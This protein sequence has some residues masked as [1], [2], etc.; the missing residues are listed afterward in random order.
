VAVMYAGQIVE[1]APTVE[2][3]SKPLHPYTRALIDSV[4]AMDQQNERLT[5]IPG[6]V[7]ALGALPHGCRFHPRCPH[8]IRECS[9][10]PPALIEARPG[11]WTRCPLWNATGVQIGVA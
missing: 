10:N 1:S 6:T 9:L 4:P 2:L 8:A 11:R 5:M 7:P 3:L